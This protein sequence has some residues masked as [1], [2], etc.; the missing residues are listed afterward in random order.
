MEHD[1]RGRAALV[2]GAS[3]G[4]GRAVAL[5][6]GRAGARVAVN[7][8]RSADA[9]AETV[10]AIQ[11]TGGEAVAIQA[12]VS[13]PAEVQRLLDQAEAR[14]G[15]LHILVNNAGVLAR[16]PFLD[17]SVEEWD[18]IHRTNLRGAFLVAQGVA[19]RMVRHGVRG[20]IVNVSSVVA[21]NASPLLTH[22]AVTKA[23]VS[24][25]TR[26]LALE[27]AKY[28]INVNE[29]NPGLIETD[30]NR[31]D[32]ENPEFVEARV[33]RIP[34]GEIGKPEDV[35]GAVLFLVSDAAR[36]VTGASIFV[37]GGAGVW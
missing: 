7:Y 34:L 16:T 10:A 6:L 1:L 18:W 8:H 29:V 12:D 4:I 3:R 27:L 5:G 32:L 22:Y 31:R 17:I 36:L 13:D 21:R 19:R 30:L 23:G 15:P 35:V 11:R 33:S 2:T 26:Q 14:L 25:L 20:R 28:R 24:M 37:D 9:A